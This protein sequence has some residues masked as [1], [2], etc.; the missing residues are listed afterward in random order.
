[1][2]D[3]W[4]M[5]WLELEADKICSSKAVAHCA[6][7]EVA[8]REGGVAV[9]EDVMLEIVIVNIVVEIANVEAVAN[10]LWTQKRHHVDG[11]TSRQSSWKGTMPTQSMLSRT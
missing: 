2:V 8:K 1:M 3:A 5:L 6:Y 9:V 11:D 7:V 4:W 10:E